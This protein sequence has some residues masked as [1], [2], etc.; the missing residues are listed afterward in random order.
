[1][2]HRFPPPA[3]FVE[4]LLFSAVGGDKAEAPGLRKLRIIPTGRN[5]LP[6][7]GNK[8]RM[9]CLSEQE[10]EGC[11]QR[12]PVRQGSKSLHRDLEVIHSKCVCVC[13]RGNELQMGEG[14]VFSQAKSLDKTSFPTRL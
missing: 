8:R 7:A 3:R 4:S 12:G 14:A 13:E 6:G 9:D 10:C 1:M 5:F 2:A 11:S